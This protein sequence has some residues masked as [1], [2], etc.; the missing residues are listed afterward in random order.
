MPDGGDTANATTGGGPAAFFRFL[1]SVSTATG[2]P[3]ELA[4]FFP[5]ASLASNSS[6]MTAGGLWSPRSTVATAVA[7]AVAAAAVARRPFR[8]AGAGSLN[9]GGEVAAA[10]AAAKEEEDDV[11]RVIFRAGTGAFKIIYLV[12]LTRF[13]Q[14]NTL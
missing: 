2:P 7:V 8:P 6:A 14:R 10:A 9:A 13:D 5:T 4:E 11:R 3:L 1:P 12:N